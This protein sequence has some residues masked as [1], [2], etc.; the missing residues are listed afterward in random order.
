MGAEIRSCNSRWTNRKDCTWHLSI[1]IVNEGG[2]VM[3]IDAL[4]ALLSQPSSFPEPIDEVLVI[5]TH[6]SVVFL[7][8]Q[9]AY[10]IKKPVNFGFLDFSTLDMRRHFCEE[11]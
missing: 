2:G 8:P 6:I 4:I 11:E 5:Q 3:N 1:I 9:H 10:K 7:T